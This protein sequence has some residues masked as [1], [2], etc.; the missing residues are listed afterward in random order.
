[1][2]QLFRYICLA[3]GA[4]LAIAP[5]AALAS[6]SGSNSTSASVASSGAEANSAA[7]QFPSAAPVLLPMPAL[8]GLESHMTAYSGFY[9]ASDGYADR[10]VTGIFTDLYQGDTGFH[11]D[12]LYVDREQNAGY[13]AFGVSHGVLGLG[14]VKLMAGT[15]TGNQNI[16]PNLY[17]SGEL[18]LQPLKGLIARPSVT[19]RHFRDGG[20]QIAPSLQVAQ[21]ISAGSAGTFVVQ[22]DGSAF[23]TKNGKT[24]WSLGGGITNV[25]S[26]GLRFGVAAHGGFMAYDSVLGTDVRSKFYG[27]GPNIGYRFHSGYEIFIRGDITTNKYYTVSGALVGLKIPL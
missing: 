3:A 25:R 21:Y 4:G 19:Y 6:G 13:A 20:S 9:Q 16:L 14:R 8:S 17:L 5:S 11:S 18:E 1:M 10:F 12:V 24:G 22:A 26:N 7:V 23:F 15:S 2:T 27:G